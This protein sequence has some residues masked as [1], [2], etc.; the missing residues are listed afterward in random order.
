[1]RSSPEAVAGTPVSDG[2]RLRA[3]WLTIAGIIR[4]IENAITELNLNVEA[5]FLLDRNSIKI[6]LQMSLLGQDQFV[7]LLFADLEVSGD[8]I[9]DMTSRD[10]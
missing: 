5:S 6:S 8:L 7:C 4:S 10:F 1:M 2:K 9:L 3:T